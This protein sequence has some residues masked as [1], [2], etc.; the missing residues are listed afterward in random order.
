L[1]SN[2]DY[3]FISDKRASN[4]Q[5]RDT[6]PARSA[7]TA[8][9]DP[10]LNRFSNSRAIS[11]DDYYNNGNSDN[12]DRRGHGERESLQRRDPAAE[13]EWG[14][15]ALT[16]GMSYLGEGLKSFAST[17]SSVAMAGFEKLS[18]STKTLQVWP[19]P[20]KR[21]PIT[22]TAAH[23]SSPSRVMLCVII[24]FVF[25]C[26]FRGISFDTN[27]IGTGHRILSILKTRCTRLVRRDGDSFRPTFKRLERAWSPL[28]LP[29]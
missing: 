24:F 29:G 2:F 27:R 17:S 21:Y 20:P 19:Y 14:D 3:H 9:K 26:R 18:Q 25:V 5:P 7:P 12:G 6:F 28:S 8:T 11:S 22:S 15:D 23:E 13:D 10:S 1:Y 4:P 16:S